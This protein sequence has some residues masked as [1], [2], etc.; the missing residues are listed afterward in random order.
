MND[1]AKLAI[2]RQ[3]RDDSDWAMASYDELDRQYHDEY[4]LIWKKQVVA[5]GLDPEPMFA[6]AV[7]AGYP[8]QELVLVAL[9]DPLMEIPH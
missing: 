5:H 9:P 1:P 2:V 7:A 4:V 6:Q 8:R 3:M